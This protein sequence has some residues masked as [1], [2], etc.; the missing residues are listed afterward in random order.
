MKII[1]TDKLSREQQTPLQDEERF[2]FSCHAGLDCFNQCCRNLNLFL[3]P[4]DVLRLKRYL[5]LTSGAF[6]DGYLEVVMREG[7]FFP[8]VL[9]TMADNPEQ[10]CPFLTAEGC[11]VYPARSYSCRLFPMEQGLRYVA[12]SSQPRLV[13]FFRPPD[14]CLGRHEAR[15][16]TPAEWIADQEATTHTEMT[17]LW[18]MLKAR[19]VNNPWGGEGPYGSR[20]RMAFMAAYNID[21]FRDF[22][23]KSSFLK[24]Y[25]VK[26]A[27]LKKIRASD[28]ELLIF[29]QEWIKTYIWGE[30]SV[31]L[32][33]K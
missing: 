27:T 6:I 12:D 8:D 2:S 17:R 11:S 25:R 18:A 5:N 28:T 16:L 24:R 33:L 10:T 9:L 29:G 30:K 4:Y 26:S 15:Q 19:F 32:R 31:L 21:A 13:N 7:N 14:F 1:E 22:V 20:A 23:F 3:Y